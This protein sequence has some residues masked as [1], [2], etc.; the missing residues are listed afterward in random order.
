MHLWAV[1]HRPPLIAEDVENFLHTISECV[2][3]QR[4]LALVFQF[5]SEAICRC[6]AAAD[7]TV[8]TVMAAEGIKSVLTIRALLYSADTM[9][10][11]LI[12][13]LILQEMM[14]LPCV[15]LEVGS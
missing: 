8:T 3:G 4:M 2:E 5:L 15:C 6:D 14:Y 12:K 10:S 9:F 11:C 1:C 13:N 7:I